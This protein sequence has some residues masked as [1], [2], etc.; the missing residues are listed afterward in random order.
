MIGVGRHG[1]GSRLRTGE[2]GPDGGAGWAEPHPAANAASVVTRGADAAS[3]A[4]SASLSCAERDAQAVLASANGLGPMTL[5]RV[6]AT[7]GSARAV[8]SLASAPAA[9]ERLI[10]ASRG[11]DGAGPAMAEKAALAVLEVVGR[12]E[13]IL[14]SLRRADVQVLTLG[15]ASYPQRLR[16]IEMPPPVLF[17]R[18]RPDALLSDRAVAVVGT[19]RPTAVG[20]MLA[21][22]IATALVRTGTTVVSG[23]AVGID[24]AAHAATLADHGTTVGV[25]GG[26]HARLYPRVHQQ[27]AEA[28]VRSGGAVVSELPPDAHPL[29]GTFPR[30]NRVIAALAQATVVVEA[31]M[32]SGA[33]ITAAW[34]LEQGR[35]CFLVP[36]ALDAPASAGCL[37]FLRECPGEARIVASVPDLIEDLGLLDPS[38]SPARPSGAGPGSAAPASPDAVLA[39]LGP[40]AAAVGRA[41]ASGGG[42]TVDDLVG[43]TG[44]QI[45]TVLAALTM[46][47]VRGCVVGAYG[48]Y[49]PAGALARAMDVP[50][51]HAS[52]ARRR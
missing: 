34:A 31:G 45:A 33:L 16:E 29:A 27:L 28:I 50:R 7:V 42:S 19:R 20:R 2:D 13:A 18:G 49:L 52:R 6:L 1:T 4:G 37:A 10:E 17:V 22:R 41:L 46:L 30:R 3:S 9:V 26:G 32:R 21:S 15:D 47:E 48:R 36:G 12:R 5:G 24:G 11:P 35:G 25:L 38:G 39:E 40:T 8:L 23:L 51:G 14:E 43:V 44:L